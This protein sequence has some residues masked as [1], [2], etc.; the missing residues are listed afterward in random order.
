MSN[1]EDNE[2]VIESTS[3][4][5]AEGLHSDEN[6]GV[7]LELVALSA[8]VVVEEVATGKLKD[9]DDEK[10]YYRLINDHFPHLG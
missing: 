1:G 2:L 3:V 5:L 10:H 6:D 9:Q 8:H 4:E 7:W